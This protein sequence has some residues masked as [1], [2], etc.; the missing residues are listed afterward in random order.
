MD[1]VVA[2]LQPLSTPFEVR[3]F[4]P[5]RFIEHSVHG[6]LHRINRIR[7][8]KQQQQEPNKSLVINANAFDAMRL[9]QVL[10]QQLYILLHLKFRK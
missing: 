3:M 10:I 4:I 8:Q 9:S 2:F 1:F 6:V 5:L 7:Q